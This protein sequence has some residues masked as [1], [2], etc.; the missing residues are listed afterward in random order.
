ML[1]APLLVANRQ[2]I[3]MS[4]RSQLAPLRTCLPQVTPDEC[5]DH[6]GITTRLISRH[7]GRCG[8]SV[9]SRISDE[10]STHVEDERESRSAQVDAMLSSASSPRE[11]VATDHS[12]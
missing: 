11:S 3:E 12:R 1:F 2:S 9:N 6:C 8:E 7:V 10:N 4:L 5:I